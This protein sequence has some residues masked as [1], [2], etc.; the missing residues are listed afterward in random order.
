[1]AT[2]A[3]DAPPPEREECPEDTPALHGGAPAGG[4][5]P[6]ESGEPAAS[7]GESPTD[8]NASGDDEPS[9]SAKDAEAEGME[10]TD[11]RTY[12]DPCSTKDKH[13][14]K[15]VD[16]GLLLPS[17][18]LAFHSC[19]GQAFP[20][21]DTNVL[22]AFV[23][24]V[25]C[26]FG[27]HPSKFF[28]RIC[29][30]YDIES[31]HL[32]PNAV[33]ALSVFT[34]LCEA[35]LGIEPNLNVWRFLYKPFYYTDQKC[36]FSI[37]FSLRDTGKYIITSFRDSWKTWRNKWF[38]ITLTKKSCIKKKH[39]MPYLTP[40]KKTLPELS[41]GEKKVVEEIMRLRESGLR[42]SHVIETFVKRRLLPL[43]ARDP[44]AF[45]YLGVK[46]PNRPNDQG[47]L[48]PLGTFYL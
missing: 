22:I 32:K 8:P 23:A 19:Y 17:T 39:L 34:I 40:A 1:M 12:W 43:Q 47:N 2:P 10:K 30:F 26:G 29:Q 48:A 11:P 28:E 21:A 27:V 18:T 37:S 31:C 20:T 36:I 9:S 46:D 13:L 3:R 38:G 24:H 42:A 7:E 33:T 25:Q 15:L 16:Q 5:A 44:L 6:T 4:D 41:E 14:E 45:A 35:F